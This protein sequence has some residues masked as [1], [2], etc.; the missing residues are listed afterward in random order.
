[1]A[2]ETLNFD[3]KE[4]K[5]AD[6]PEGIQRLVTVYEGTHARRVE[7]E[8]QHISLSAAL[9][10][11]SADITSAVQAAEKEAEAANAEKAPAETVA[12]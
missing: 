5:V 1:M 3:G 11:L 2:I 10:Q 4:I 6:L 9:R 8:N 7:V 12:E